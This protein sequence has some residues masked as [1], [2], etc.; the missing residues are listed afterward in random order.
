MV[1]VINSTP[2]P[3]GSYK[4]YFLRVPPEITTAKSAV[5]WTFDIDADKYSPRRQT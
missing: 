2:E 3:D 4:H 1:R 5:A